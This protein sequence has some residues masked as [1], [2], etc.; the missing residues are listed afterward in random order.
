MKIRKATKKDL[1]EIAEL[2]KKELSKS[3][4]NERDSIKNILKSLDF[5]YKNA[6]IYLIEEKRIVGVLVFQI[7]LWWEGS[8]IIIQDL[9]VNKEFQKKGIGKLLMNFVE[10]YACN[11]NVKRIYFGTNRKS[12]SIKFYKKLGYE[13]NKDRIS[14]SKKIK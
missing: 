10:R 12:P 6:E 14:M 1:K 13:T 8:V 3:P 4:F 7:E 9:T 11:N 2:M 5:Y